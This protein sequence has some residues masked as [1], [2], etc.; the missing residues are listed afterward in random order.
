MKHIKVLSLSLLALGL[1]LGCQKTSADP[2]PA[3]TA[4]AGA[5]AGTAA[6]GGSA[7]MTTDA[8]GSSGQPDEEKV[9][10]GER[11][12]SC[13]ATSDCADELSCIVTRDCP[14]GVA[15]A[16][17]TCQP[18]NFNLTGTGKTCHVRDCKTKAD[19][20]GEMPEQAPAKCANRESIC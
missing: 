2:E 13:N 3:N 8:G 4:G 19:C 10:K 14:A 18:S 5:V 11:G 16:N 1:S 20:C 17:K 7:A 6:G 12:T 9:R 15:C